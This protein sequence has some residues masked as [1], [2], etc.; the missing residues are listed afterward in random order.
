MDYI[1]ELVQIVFPSVL[2]TIYMVFFSSLFSTIIGMFIGI[3]VYVT[4]KGNIMENS[5]VFKTLNSIVNIG[6]SVPFVIIIIAVFPVSKFIVGTTIGSTAA[7]VPLTIAA[8]PFAARVIESSL[9]ELNRGVI[10]A[11]ISAGASN[12]QIITMVMLPE[13]A[14]SIIL[15]VTLTII[16]II[17]Y[18]T[19][20][21]VIG[22]GGLGNVAILYGYQRFRTDILIITVVITI[23]L[24][25]IIQWAG[26]RLAAKYNRN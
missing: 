7:I 22:G 17:G 16:S 26:S 4:E 18:S 9:R 2:E 3:G 12:F 14:H 1:N 11:S 6:R 24:V 10:E 5:A 20:A 23:I 25:Q 21:G 8:A 15:G 13:T 19:M